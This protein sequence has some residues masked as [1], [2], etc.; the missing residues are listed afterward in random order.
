MSKEKEGVLVPQVD[1]ALENIVKET[2]KE[3]DGKTVTILLGN[4]PEQ[5]KLHANKPISLEGAICSPRRFCEVR[6]FERTKSHAMVSL[7]RGE[8]VL[9]VDEQGTND[10][11]TVTGRVRIAKEFEDLGINAEREYTP[12]G[13]AKK[14]KLKRSIFAN[15]TEHAETIAVLRNL[16]AK[17]NQDIEKAKDDKG[18]LTDAMTQSVESNCPDSIKVK[19]PLI[20]GGEPASIELLIVLEV[21]NGKIICFLESIDAAELIEE[22]RTEAVAKEVEAIKDLTTVIYE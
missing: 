7:S 15:K 11:Y 12:E 10:K 3:A 17:V 6:K 18:N 20:E 2:I 13:L 14:L 16:K 9:V 8:I 22:F 21:D 5:L 1:K 19:I 4:A